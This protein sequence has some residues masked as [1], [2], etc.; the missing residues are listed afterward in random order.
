MFQIILGVVATLTQKPQDAVLRIGEDTS[1]E[2]GTSLENRPVDWKF[3]SLATS[4]VKRLVFGGDLV[5]D[6]KWKFQIL[7]NLVY[8]LQISNVTVEDVGT[9]I[10]IDDTGLGPDQ[11]SAE[12]ILLG[13]FNDE[14]ISGLNNL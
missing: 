3:Q 12:L 8:K 10:C 9:Y 7:K 13:K 14:Y 1:F 11:A 5:H 6:L 4:E 2:C